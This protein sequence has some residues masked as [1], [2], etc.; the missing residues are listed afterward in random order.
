MFLHRIR[1]VPRI[2]SGSFGG[3]MSLLDCLFI[4]WGTAGAMLSSSIS[5]IERGYSIVC[6][7][8][9]CKY[10]G[11]HLSIFSNVDGEPSSRNLSL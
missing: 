6:M 11:K 1:Y 4:A 3:L 9:L 8:S 2:G 5:F 10:V 7:C